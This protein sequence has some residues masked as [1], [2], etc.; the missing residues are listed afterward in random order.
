MR[1]TMRFAALTLCLTALGAGSA[2]SQEQ[3]AQTPIQS[4]LRIAQAAPPLLP[5]S[6]N[7]PSTFAPGELVAE[8][9]RFFGT[10][11]R[12]LAE[13]VEREKPFES[14]LSFFRNS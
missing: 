13:L 11:S 9:H 5:Q 4:E 2:L 3:A 1:A 12:G 7:R 6:Q 10:V 8:G 14:S